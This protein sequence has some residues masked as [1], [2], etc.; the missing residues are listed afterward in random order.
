[1]TKSLTQ[2]L[3]FE[4]ITVEMSISKHHWTECR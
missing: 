4:V 1:V 3:A 2:L